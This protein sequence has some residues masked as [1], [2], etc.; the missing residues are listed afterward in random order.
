M[1]FYKMKNLTDQ[2]TKILIGNPGC[3]KTT[4]LI[5]LMMDEIKKGV[6]LQKIGFGS[7]S[8][9]AIDEAKM[10]AL[11]SL[12]S[13]QQISESSKESTKELSNFKTLHAMAF[14]LLGLSPDN[15]MNDFRMAEFG[16][17]VGLT[18]SSINNDDNDPT[19]R[20]ITQRQTLGDK[21]LHIISVANLY[22]KSIR[23]YAT[24]IADQLPQKVSIAYIEDIASRYRDFK[25][26]NNVFDYT[27]MLV[28]AKTADL[29]T[30]ELEVYF[31]DEAQDLSTLQWILVD[32][33]ASTVKKV[34]IA[35]DDKQAINTF[36]GADVTTFLNVPGK[37]EVL[38]QSHRI[39]Q[40]VFKLA[41]KLMTKMEK[42]RPEG[43]DWKPREEKGLV[44]SGHEFPWQKIQNGEDWLVL[45]RARFQLDKIAEGLMRRNEDGPILFTVDGCAPISIDLLR[46]ITLM[47]AYQKMGQIQ[48]LVTI[49]DTDTPEKRKY[50][51]GVI[52]LFKKYIPCKHYAQPWQVDEDFRTALGR[53]WSVAMCK[54]PPYMARYI[55]ALFP[56]YKERGDDLFVNAPIRLMTM[57]KSKGREADNVVVLLD[58]PAQVRENMFKD[59]TECKLFYVAVTRAKHNLYLVKQNTH[60]KGFEYFL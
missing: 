60:Q 56:I 34:I 18:F 25:I 48:E 6:P 37:V 12:I 50:K 27:D 45:S 43:A 11:E 19:K 30:P 47:R 3:G 5:R 22:N 33:M 14:R 42:Y 20:S 13:A 1:T 38:E 51:I 29:V 10:R 2:N 49:R 59:D 28:M 40:S 16:K 9:A 46:A 4:A 32:R 41:N 53:P 52:K 31:L 15:L 26:L 36:A 57:H 39:P 55:E 24:T 35:G 44:K 54:I 8:V 17:M 23:E 7:F 58:V 21:V